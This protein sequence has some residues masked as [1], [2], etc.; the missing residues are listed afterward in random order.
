MSY[1]QQKWKYIMQV[2]LRLLPVVFLCC[3]IRLI[4]INRYTLVLVTQI[5]FI[6]CRHIVPWH[7]L[8]D[9]PH[10]RLRFAIC[11]MQHCSQPCHVCT[12]FFIRVNIFALAMGRVQSNLLFRLGILYEFLPQ[13]EC[14]VLA[15]MVK[16]LSRF[17]QKGSNKIT[18]T[19]EITMQG[20]SYDS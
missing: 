15:I 10:S 18:C 3:L 19:K 8:G 11:N 16:R 20:C 6:S 4:Y 12:V 7:V 13:N 1:P 9:R 5:K 14:A 2:T 17:N